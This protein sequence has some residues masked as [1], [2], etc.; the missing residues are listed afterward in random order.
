[1]ITANE[2][3]I[4][5]FLLANFDSDYSINE[6]AKKT[7]LAPNGA[8]EALKKFEERGVLLPKKIANLKSYKVNFES[9]EANKM[10]ELAL[11]PDYKEPKISYRYNDLKPLNTVTKLCILFGSYITKKEKPNDIDAL[12]VIE[13]ADYKKYSQ[14]LDKVKMAMPFKLH[15]VIQTKD[16]LKENLKKRDKIIISA[17]SDGV[18]LWGHEFLVEVI[19][20]VAEREA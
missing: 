15:D 5:R 16:D 17:I 1:M 11:I 13:K 19:R 12:F 4:L 14:Y 9:I 2:K 8:Y 3:K 6:I 18:I 20:N 10:L 7:G